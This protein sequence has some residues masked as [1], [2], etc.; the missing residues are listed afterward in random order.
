MEKQLPVVHFLG[1]VSPIACRSRESVPLML[2]T[3]C[4][5]QSNVTTGG[6]NYS[7]YSNY[8]LLGGIKQW[9]QREPIRIRNWIIKWNLNCYILTDS[10]PYVWL[11]HR[12]RGHFS[13]ASQELRSSL[14]KC[15]LTS[16]HLLQRDVW[17]FEVFDWLH[18]TEWH[19]WWEH[20][21]SYL[22]ISLVRWCQPET[23]Y[24]LLIAYGYKHS[25]RRLIPQLQQ[26]HSLS[27]FCHNYSVDWKCSC[28]VC[29]KQNSPVFW[30]LRPTFREQGQN[31]RNILTDHNNICHS[32]CHN[33]S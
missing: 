25:G 27:V 8:C 32:W 16:L 21:C 5:Q 3:P 31:K 13:P 15:F 7:K 19:G 6:T 33:V 14:S 1:L 22:S 24:R 26:K 28:C 11:S 23:P 2:A 10:H 4:R 18:S 20:A 29:V 9:W 30:R 12:S 17:E